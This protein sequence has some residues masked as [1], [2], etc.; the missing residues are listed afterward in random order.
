MA[1]DG[2]IKRLHYREYW[3]GWYQ[4]TCFSREKRGVG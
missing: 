2:L 4:V 3:L 1:V